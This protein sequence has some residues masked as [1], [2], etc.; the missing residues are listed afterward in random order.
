MTI[1]I[2]SI[3]IFAYV[4]NIRKALNIISVNQYQSLHLPLVIKEG[5]QMIKIKKS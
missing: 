5:I 2:K 3:P 1:E 4:I